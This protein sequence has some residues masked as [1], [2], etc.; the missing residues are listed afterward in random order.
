MLKHSQPTSGGSAACGPHQLPALTTRECARCGSWWLLQ[1]VRQA[2]GTSQLL[3]V[4]A[5]LPLRGPLGS[6]LFQSKQ[7]CSPH[8]NGVTNH[9]LQARA[10]CL[11]QE[12]EVRQALPSRT[13]QATRPC[14][15]AQLRLCTCCASVA[16]HRC[17]QGSFTASK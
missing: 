9:C 13:A 12:A 14:A 3:R 16:V 2:V 5:L 1:D 11:L 10:L 4:R 15:P 6:K 8:P 17:H 7:A